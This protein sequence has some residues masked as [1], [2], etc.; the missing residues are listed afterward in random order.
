MTETRVPGGRLH[1][2]RSRGAA[3]GLLLLLLGVWG[4][5]I[6]FIGPLFDFAY[7]PDRAWAWTT[8]RGWLEVLPGAVTA[9]GGLLLLMS[10][11]RATAM[12][13]GWLAVAGGAWF[14]VGRALAG[15]LGLGDAGAPVATTDAQRVLLELAYFSG[16]GALIVFL[17]A[18]ALGRVSVRSVRDVAW[19]DRAVAAPA[20]T[21]YSDT[22]DQRT[23]VIGPTAEAARRRGGW[24]TMF[25]GG[26]R[27]HHL[28][29]R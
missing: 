22:D 15:P 13:G 2:P 25:R 23:E 10:A 6:P 9:L 7:S 19:A 8:G 27:D 18:A 4:A 12:L 20:D 16:L 28:A 14:I 29:H 1:M 26:R 3:S 5:L 11:N 24:R 21:A 17:G